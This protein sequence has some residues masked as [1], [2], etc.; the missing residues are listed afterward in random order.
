MGDGRQARPR[1]PEVATGFLAEA[2]DTEGGLAVPVA[3]DSLRRVELV[4]RRGFGQ[5]A[6]GAEV[7]VGGHADVEFGHGGVVEGMIIEEDGDALGGF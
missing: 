7:D 1:V 4:L 6:V 2:V 5:G 3:D